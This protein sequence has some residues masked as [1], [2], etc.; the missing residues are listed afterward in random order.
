M[1]KL[2]LFSCLLL[3]V[4]TIR[5]NLIQAV[6]TETAN[7][8]FGIHLAV[9]D[10]KD[11]QSAAQLVNSSGGDWG[12]VTL[13]IGEN[14]RNKQKWQKIFDQ[15]RE[16][17]LIPILRLATVFENENWRRAKLKDA[18]GWTE[19]L[20][21]LNWVVKNRYVILFNE[22]NHANEW[23]GAVDPQGY[24]EIAYE[25]AKT[26]KNKN[27]DFFVMLAGLDAAAPHQPPNHEDETVFLRKIPTEIFDYL[28]GW[29]SHSYPNHGFIGSPLGDGRNSVKNYLWELSLL[30]QLRVRKNLPVFI[31]EAGWPHAEGKTYQANLYPQKQAAENFKI[32]FARVIDDPKVMAITPFVLNYQDTPFDHFSWQKLGS[33]QEFYP[34]YEVVRNLSKTK[35][36]PEQVQ[37]LKIVNDLPEKLITASTYQI[38]II[39]KNLGQAIWRQKDGYQLKLA[40]VDETVRDH[41]FSDFSELKPFEEQTVDLYLKTEDTPGKVSLSL[42]VS[43]KG[44]LVSETFP[45][46]L[47]IIPPPN[48]KFRVNLFPKRKDTGNDFKILVYNTEEQLVFEKSGIKVKNGLG[49][50]QGVRNL[51]VGEKYRLVILK[52]Y[53][54]PRQ[55][56]LTIKEG[57]NKI[58]FKRML[59]LDLNQDGNFSLKDIFF[60]FTNPQLMSLFWTS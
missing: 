14:D 44:R 36:E 13:V 58:S 46:P 29:A 49:E 10:D 60:S 59:P 4:F 20:N 40:E 38:P 41:F 43:K 31:T 55:E 26:L 21:S 30:K 54:L 47:E 5:P 57:E 9:A 18:Q 22:P 53:Y 34:Q 7:N 33:K 25:F 19:F 24:G 23:G 52:P 39:V 1:L 16:L 3:L 17:H 12:Y 15:L 27:P 8:K 56:F 45:W 32:Y 51:A 11:L 50:V 6:G 35:G 28:D 42:A 48:I 37:K 2:W